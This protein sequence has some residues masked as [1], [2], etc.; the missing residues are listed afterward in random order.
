M[1]KLILWMIGVSCVIALVAILFFNNMEKNYLEG[2]DDF[3][4]KN[5]FTSSIE[6]RFVLSEF[7][8][9]A[10]L[11]EDKHSLIYA[12]QNE[13][14]SKYFTQGQ[15]QDVSLSQS[16][17]SHWIILRLKVED[18]KSKSRM[19]SKIIELMNAFEW[20]RIESEMDGAIYLSLE[21]DLVINISLPYYLGST[22]RKIENFLEQVAKQV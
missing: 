8:K 7:I 5:G 15:M 4:K 19:E 2:L 9:F 21:D 17:R 12:R 22:W 3:S 20:N 14:K 11:K 10:S 13:L 18:E 6:G 1:E 16:Q